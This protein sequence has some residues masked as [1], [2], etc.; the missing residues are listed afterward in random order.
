[1]W[2]ERKEMGKSNYI[3]D[4]YIWVYE[5]STSR[6]LSKNFQEINTTYY[7]PYFTAEET[8]SKEQLKNQPKG[9]QLVGEKRKQ[10]HNSEKGKNRESKLKENV[11]KSF[12]WPDLS[13]I[14]LGFLSFVYVL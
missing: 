7:Q 4:L 6:I 11:L 10:H 3:N 13:Q 8:E 5:Q 9:T 12:F 14:C 2:V 1:M